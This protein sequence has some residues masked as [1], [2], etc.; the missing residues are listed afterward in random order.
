MVVAVI[1]A[2]SS[3]LK[4]GLGNLSKIQIRL[5]AVRHDVELR[6]E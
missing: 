4:C 3:G 2:E 6:K 1:L 5:N